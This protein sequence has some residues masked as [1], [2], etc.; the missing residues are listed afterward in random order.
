MMLLLIA[1][2]LPVQ[3]GGDVPQLTELDAPITEVVVHKNGARVTRE[4]TLELPAGRSR[5]SID[6]FRLPEGENLGGDELEVVS[7]TTGE[8]T[9]IL[10]IGLEERTRQPTAEQVDALDERISSLEIELTSAR[11]LEVNAQADLDLLDVFGRRL[12]EDSGSVVGTDVLN[13]ELLEQQLEFISGKRMAILQVQEA[14]RTVMAQLTRALDSARKQLTETGRTQRVATAQIEVDSTGGEETIKVTWL[15]FR[16]SWSPEL[17]VRT[18]ESEG[19]TTLQLHANVS[20]R[21]NSDW[22]GIRLLL[23][24]TDLRGGA[25]RDIEPVSVDTVEEDEDSETTPPPRKIAEATSEMVTV[26]T[27]DQP[28]FLDQGDGKLLVKSFQS[29]CLLEAIMRPVTQAGA[30][31]RGSIKN[32][33]ELVLLPCSMRLYLDNQ[34]VGMPALD[35]K[36]DPGETFN[37]WFSELE[38]MEIE[39]EILE[40]ETVKTGLLGGGRLTTTR[41]RITIRNDRPKTMKIIVEDRMPISRSEDIEI[42][43]KNVTPELSTDPAYLDGERKLGILRWEVTLPPGSP[44]AVP[45]SIEWTVNVSRSSEVDTTPIPR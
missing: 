5:L 26:Y 2:L 23:S 22:N 6:L 41:Y 19:S 28:T 35:R 36:V 10:S 9:R 44:D 34:F 39:R 4:T 37:I 21:T 40:R 15:E 33:S 27:I 3:A 12:V 42:S 38:G 14:S 18:D 32:T 16:S 20:N 29:D 13:L 24:T 7:A 45:L 30:W 1:N 31:S 11:Q 8:A 25:P 43:L 17:S